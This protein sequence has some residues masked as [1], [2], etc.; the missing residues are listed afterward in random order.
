LRDAVP[1]FCSDGK[2][3]GEHLDSR[4]AHEPVHLPEDLIVRLSNYGRIYGGTLF[5]TLL[6][7]L[8]TLLVVRT[9]RSDICVATA[10]ANRSQPNTDRVIGLFQ[11]TT[12]VRTSIDPNLPFPE[13]LSRVRNSIL[14]AHAR[15][16]IPFDILV[17]RL[18]KEEGL[19]PASLIQ[20]YF[21]LQNPLRRPLELCDIA[22]QP[23][24]HVYRE[25]QPVMPINDTWLS[26][27]LKE[28]PCGITGSCIYKHSLFK[29]SAVT[30]W[31][32]DFSKI[33]RNAVGTFARLLNNIGDAK[34]EGPAKCSAN[35]D[36][37]LRIRLDLS[38]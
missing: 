36:L 24:G 5:M 14:E 32:E 30:H 1:V 10:M 16:E 31:M 27:M 7:G 22:T 37:R 34:P 25:G 18:S 28:R 20:I 17:E 19:D 2:G 11:N 3:R 12:I 4:S 13:A 38:A 15:Q 6:T 23:F 9:G 35:C 33:L 21:T 29:R 26:L 8:K